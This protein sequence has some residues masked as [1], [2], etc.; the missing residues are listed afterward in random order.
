MSRK[1]KFLGD[2]FWECRIKRFRGG[3]CC[4]KKQVTTGFY[5]K[6][7]DEVIAKFKTK[8]EASVFADL[9][10]VKYSPMLLDWDVKDGVESKEIFKSFH[11]RHRLNDLIFLVC[12]GYGVLDF[13]EHRD[14]KHGL[15][16]SHKYVHNGNELDVNNIIQDYIIGCDLNSFDKGLIDQL[17][18]TMFN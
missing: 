2:P 6:P 11:A 16:F 18:N 15:Y 12:S 13:V 1:V 17:K 4:I 10:N 8:R 7:V 5:D 3:W 9:I 14:L